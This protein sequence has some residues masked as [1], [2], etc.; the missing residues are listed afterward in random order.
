MKTTLVIATMVAA[1]L[2][3]VSAASAAEAWLSPKQAQ[4]RHERR[5]VPGA[6]PDLLDRSAKAVSPNLAAFRQSLRTA[7]G[8]TPDLIVRRVVPVSPR[9]L[10]EQPERIKSF[11]VA[12]LK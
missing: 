8:A 6:T 11:Q 12:P 5:T 7:P 2:S 3:V 4:L 10:A 9:L 1:T